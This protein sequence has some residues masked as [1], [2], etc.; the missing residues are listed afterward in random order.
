MASPWPVSLESLQCFAASLKEGAYKSSQGFFQS[1]FTYQRRH[2]Q[3]EESQVL[4]G[5]AKTTP[6]VSPEE[7]GPSTLKDSF[8]VENLALIRVEHEIEPFSME[9]SSHGRDLLVVACW[10]MMRELGSGSLTI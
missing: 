5:A 3:L 7:L 8:D 2:L 9:S 10:Y 4:K 1:V 6:V